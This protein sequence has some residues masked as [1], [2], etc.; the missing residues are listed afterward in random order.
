MNVK[1]D[2]LSL[3]CRARAKKEKEVIR[4]ATGHLH[5]KKNI[6]RMVETEGKQIG[7]GDFRVGGR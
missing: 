5:K 7:R 3:W 2:Q 6:E 1:L 4:I